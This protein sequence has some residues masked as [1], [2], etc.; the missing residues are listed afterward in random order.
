[1]RLSGQVFVCA[2]SSVFFMLRAAHGRGILAPRILLTE[3]RHV[4]ACH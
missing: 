4:A 1:M 2:E 3:A